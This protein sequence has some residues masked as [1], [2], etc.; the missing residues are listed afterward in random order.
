MIVLCKKKHTHTHTQILF[1]EKTNGWPLFF[2]TFPSG[3]FE[4]DLF[5]SEQS[6][7]KMFLIRYFP[8]SLPKQNP[9]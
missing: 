8:E 3:F 5:G 4:G 6:N 9:D 7:Q 2:F 1:S